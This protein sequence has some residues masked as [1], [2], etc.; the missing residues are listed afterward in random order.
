[1]SACLVAKSQQSSA[2]NKESFFM[3]VE[4]MLVLVYTHVQSSASYGSGITSRQANHGR[5]TRAWLTLIGQGLRW[6][7]VWLFECASRKG[8]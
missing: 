8:R 3:L 1:M 6:R 4:V 7:S 5:A 2:V